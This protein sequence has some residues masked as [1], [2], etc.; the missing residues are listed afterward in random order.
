MADNDKSPLSALSLSCISII[1]AAAAAIANAQASKG[2]VMIP[3][4]H[5][6][7]CRCYQRMLQRLCCRCHNRCHCTGKRG[8]GDDAVASL[9]TLSPLLMHMSVHTAA[10]DAVAIA[11]ASM[12]Q[13][14]ALSL[15]S[16][17]RC[18]CHHQCRYRAG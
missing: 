2:R 12:G 7:R 13:S 8:T 14:P 9:P 10:A 15:L 18:R 17:W 11:Q 3:M 5:H 16:T 6:L 1:R 4:H